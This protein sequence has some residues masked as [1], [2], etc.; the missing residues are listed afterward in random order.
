MTV[1]ILSVRRRRGEQKIKFHLQ[2][3]LCY[4]HGDFGARLDETMPSGDRSIN[5]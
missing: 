5:R 3:Q 1:T 2:E 4:I